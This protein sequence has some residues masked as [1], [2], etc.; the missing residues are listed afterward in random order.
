MLSCRSHIRHGFSPFTISIDVAYQRPA[1]QSYDKRRLI[2][3]LYMTRS[4]SV[5]RAVAI[6]LLVDV[7]SI[8][9][10]TIAAAS[11]VQH[12]LRSNIDERCCIPKPVLVQDSYPSAAGLL[13]DRS[14]DSEAG[15][16]GAAHGLGPG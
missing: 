2:I 9:R 5:H 16:G 6:V 4:R 14:R 7:V 3:Q 10:F 11:T 13:A 1:P 8:Y 15:H 12:L